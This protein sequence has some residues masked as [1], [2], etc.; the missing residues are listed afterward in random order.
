MKL[1]TCAFATLAAALLP[2]TLFAQTPSLSCRPLES[3]NTYIEPDEKV[4][5]N[6]VCKIVSGPNV[7]PKPAPPRATTTTA[8]EAPNAEATSPSADPA[9]VQIST[10]IPASPA[11]APAVHRKVVLEDDTPV[12]LVLSEN[13]SSASATTGQTIAFEVS[14]DVLVDGLLVVPRG[15]LAWGTV[16]EA[17][18]KRRLGRAGHLDVNIDKVRLA[19]GEKVLLSASSHAKGGTHTVAMTTGIVVTSLVIWPAAPFFL[20]MHGHDV[21]IPKGTKIEAFTNGDANLD[22]ANFALAPK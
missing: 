18:A 3:G 17:Q 13:L 12:H 8:P 4:I 15:A 16:T 19:D 11:P 10:E 21:T 1:R 9:A 7:A 20:F 5:G 22:G 14:E 6:Q 2:A